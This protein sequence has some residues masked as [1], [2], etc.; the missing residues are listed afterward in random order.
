MPRSSSFRVRHSRRLGFTLVELL[1]VIAIIGVLVALLLPAVQSAR[2]AGRRM[3]C[4]NHLK[5]YGLG[6]HNYHDNYGVFPINATGP[7]G[8]APPRL[9]WQVR[10][11]PYMEQQAI[12]NGIDFNAAPDPRRLPLL[13]GGPILWGV[14]LPYAYCPSDQYPKVIMTREGTPSPR[15]QCNYG[16]SLGSQNINGTVQTSCHPF[17]VFEQR[18]EG[19]NPRF[20]EMNPIDKRRVSGIFA[21]SAVVLRIADVTDGTSNT[22][23]V[24]EGLPACHWINGE[25]TTPYDAQPGT[26]I[27]S[28]GNLFSMGGGMS[29][30][31]PINEM[32]SCRRSTRISDPNCN[33][34]AGHTMQYAYGFKSRHPGGVQFTLADGSVRFVSQQI[35]HLM[36][37]NL[38]GRDEGNTIGDF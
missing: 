5:Q 24:G 3:T 36:Y 6:I 7:A 23:M 17:T 26:W 21:F 38:G 16:G 30:I 31:T 19:G 14:T 33:P 22:L 12:Y 28:W 10:I 34:P 11:L 32:T 20:G 1:V 2:E 4:G 15:A 35:N 25:D 37:Q 27:N 13:G 18:M 29:T 8:N 9:T